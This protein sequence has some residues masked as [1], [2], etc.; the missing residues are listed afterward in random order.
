MYSEID[1]WLT[2]LPIYAKSLLW[3][4]LCL[5]AI[6]AIP[7]VWAGVTYRPRGKGFWLRIRRIGIV[8]VSSAVM[9][10]LLLLALVRVAGLDAS[11]KVA[12]VGSFLVAGTALALQFAP[13]WSSK[14][15]EEQAGRHAVRLPPQ[16]PPASPDSEKVTLASRNRPDISG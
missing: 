13:R 2:G 11:D 1:H 14:W 15:D 3:A 7:S 10:I 5:A 6:V 16:P 9:A 4:W 12:S 8:V